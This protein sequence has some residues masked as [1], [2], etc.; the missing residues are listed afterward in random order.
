MAKLR[1]EAIAAL[2]TPSRIAKLVNME[3]NFHIKPDD[4]VSALDGVEL[5]DFD[6]E[7]EETRAISYRS[8]SG[9]KHT[10]STGICRAFCVDRHNQRIGVSLG[11]DTGVKQ[12][13]RSRDSRKRNA[14]NFT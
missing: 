3:S 13:V 14:Y 7:I 2:Y 8:E 6:I 10:G 4:I 12:G 1:L 11:L 5:L 9:I